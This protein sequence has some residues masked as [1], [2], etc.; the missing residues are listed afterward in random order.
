M[1]TWKERVLFVLAG[2]LM[3]L[4]GSLGFLWRYAPEK[5]DRIR[6][7]ISWATLETVVLDGAVIVV[8]G[9]AV[10]FGALSLVIAVVLEDY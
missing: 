5:L 3:L 8:C 10:L 7:S 9:G 4:L 2:V 1:S 6:D